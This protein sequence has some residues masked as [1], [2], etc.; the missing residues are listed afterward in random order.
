MIKVGVP[1]GLFF[2][3]YYPMLKAF[4]EEL[5]AEV[6]ISPPTNRAI[7]SAGCSRVVA[8]T[9]LPVKIFIGHVLSLAGKCEYIFIPA[10][11]SLK[12]KV[13][14]CPK[15]LGLPDLVNAVLPECPTIIRIDADI[16]K[17]KQSIWQSIYKL[18]RYFT[19]NQAK[20]EKAAANALEVLAQY[21]RLMFIY[22]LTPVQAME[23]LNGSLENKPQRYFSST[24]ETK[25]GIIGHPYILYDE[26]VGQH[27]FQYLK[28]SDCAV[29]TPEMLADEQLQSA[30]IR[31][32]G[33]MYWAY[34]EC[35][36]GAAERYLCNGID[37]IVGIMAFGCGPDSLMF[38]IISHQAR[39]NNIP[40]ISLTLDEHMAK[41]SLVTRLEAFLDMIRLKRRKKYASGSAKSW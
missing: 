23:I 22:R 3:Q 31:T 7:L 25:I 29:V 32:T 24:S 26:L 41:T 9:C 2:Y 19:V 8:D 40:F 35:V 34:E 17:G 38:N 30:V 37:G 33:R 4:F 13:Y 11:R 16:N 28:S 12:S 20:L 5:G 1:R 10:I 15:F 14:Y 39:D 36:V 6:L 18:G 27:I 21:R